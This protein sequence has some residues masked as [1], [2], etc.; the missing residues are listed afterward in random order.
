MALGYAVAAQVLAPI[1]QHVARQNRKARQ[2]LAQRGGAL[3]VING[4]MLAVVGRMKSSEA[5]ERLKR[6]Q[7]VRGQVLGRSPLAP[8]ES[9]LTRERSLRRSSFDHRWLEG[10]KCGADLVAPHAVT[11]EMNSSCLPLGLRGNSV[12]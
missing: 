6:C 11:D 3:D 8:G 12:T 9:E 4:D 7:L 10:L 5:Y 2:S 1:A